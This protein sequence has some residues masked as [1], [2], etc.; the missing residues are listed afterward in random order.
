MLGTDVL[1]VTLALR[2]GDECD[3]RHIRKLDGNLVWEK[4]TEVDH[5]KQF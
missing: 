2:A 1:T 5:E 4:N 3:A